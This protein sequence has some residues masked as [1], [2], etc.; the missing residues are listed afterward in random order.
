NG[1]RDASYGND[2]V[3]G[4]L[5]PKGIGRI[6]DVKVLNNGSFLVAT[7]SILA[8]FTSQG[9][10]DPSFP[11]LDIPAGKQEIRPLADGNLALVT[12]ANPVKVIL[13]DEFGNLLSQSQSDPL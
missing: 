9:E 5:G 13:F 1:E 8:K 11:V 6:N 10:L 3:T 2:G 7:D 4:P 12:F